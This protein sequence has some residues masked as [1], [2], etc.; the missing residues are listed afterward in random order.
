MYA[1]KARI[2]SLIQILDYLACQEVM[3]ILFSAIKVDEIAKQSI[4]KLT[5]KFKPGH[6]M[7]IAYVSDTIKVAK[8]GLTTRGKVGQQ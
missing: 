3:I 1:K 5:S 2:Y 7:H 6:C 8:T 4:N